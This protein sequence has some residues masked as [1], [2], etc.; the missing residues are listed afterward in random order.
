MKIKKEEEMVTA[1]A[2]YVENLDMRELIVLTPT[3]FLN[4]TLKEYFADKHC[5]ACQAMGQGW[6]DCLNLYAKLRHGAKAGSN[7][8]PPADN[9]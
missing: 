1:N 3:S 6:R 9:I 7:P 2:Q 5:H 8:I 4:R